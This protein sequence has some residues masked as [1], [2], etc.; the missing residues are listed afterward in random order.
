MSLFFASLPLSLSHLLTFPIFVQYDPNSG[1]VPPPGT[2]E[3]WTTTKRRVNHKT[4]QVET[5]VQRQ[6]IMEDGKVIADS[7]PQVTTKTTEDQKSDESEDTKHRRLGDSE[8]PEKYRK[9]IGN[10]VVS[11]K[12]VT[13]NLMREAKEENFQYHDE[14]LRE[15][16][17][18]DIHR[19]A[20]EAPNELIRI[21]NE[22][23]Q[24]PRGKLVHFS[25]KGRKINDRD[26]I[27]EVSR[28]DN[29]GLLSTETTQT[30]HHEEYEDDELPEGEDAKQLQEPSQVMY[31][32]L[33]YGRPTTSYDV[34]EHRTSRTNSSLSVSRNV[35][36]KHNKANKK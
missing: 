20:I 3:E 12:T 8:V 13:R 14:S 1:L 10:Q 23:P 30:N 5:R 6:I 31:R 7:G 25:A 18:Q 29:D 35:D 26:E 33:E 2:Q 34:D 19:R 4:K 15:L 16:E 11:E 32:Q 28:L 27:Q 36:G 21:D 17:G 24:I 9:E 22:L